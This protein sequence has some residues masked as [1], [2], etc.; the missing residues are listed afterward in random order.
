VA[1]A[2]QGEE[3]VRSQLEMDPWACQLGEFSLTDKRF[4]RISAFMAHTLFD[5]N[6]GGETETAMWR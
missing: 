4:S 5:E 3:F 6:Y 2:D 1:S